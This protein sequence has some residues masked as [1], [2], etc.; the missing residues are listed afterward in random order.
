[1]TEKLGTAQPPGGAIPF[2]LL[3]LVVFNTPLKN[4]TNRQLGLL[5]IPNIWKN[6][7]HVPNHQPVIDG[8]LPTF[9]QFL[10]A[11]FLTTY[12]INTNAENFSLEDHP[13][14]LVRG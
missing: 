1:V 8:L 4:M 11:L 9:R 5:S 6:N 14:V 7:I 2:T 13:T 12:N 10:T 3:W